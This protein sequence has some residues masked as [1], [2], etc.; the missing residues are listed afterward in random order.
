MGERPRC[1]TRC[2][3]RG[4]RC[5]RPRR[6]AGRPG[7][8]VSKTPLCRPW[9]TRCGPRTSRSASS[10][11]TPIHAVQECSRPSSP[12]SPHSLPDAFASKWARGACRTRAK[13]I[14][15]NSTRTVK[16]VETFVEAMRAL[17]TGDTVTA[18]S[19]AFVLNGL[20]LKIEPAP[21][22]PVDV[23]AI[24]PKM[25]DL[26]ARGRRRCF[27]LSRCQPGVSPSLH[28]LLGEFAGEVRPRPGPV[29][30]L[31]RRSRPWSP[32]TSPRHAVHWRSQGCC[33]FA[34]P[35]SKSA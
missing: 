34:C 19:E 27:A 25:I 7:T 26:A 18:S 29:P 31:R 33:A 30:D 4:G 10:G 24:R 16:G 5:G 20:T 35:N 12:R 22:I 21:P 13:W 6:R 11:S 28:R 1:W 17:L 2:R 9:P 8:S 32:T 15:V 14:G 3:S 23:M